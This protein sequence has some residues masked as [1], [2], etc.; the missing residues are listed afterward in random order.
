MPESD[1]NKIKECLETNSSNRFFSSSTTDY[2]INKQPDHFKLT[3]CSAHLTYTC[4]VTIEL[5]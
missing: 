4:N 5:D 1:I 3:C 2:F